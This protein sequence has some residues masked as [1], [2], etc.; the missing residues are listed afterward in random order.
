L[1]LV[2]AATRN[3]R[4]KVAGRDE[5]AILDRDDNRL[6]GIDRGADLASV[7]IAQPRARRPAGHQASIEKAGS[8]A[9]ILPWPDRGGQIGGDAAG[10]TATGEIADMRSATGAVARR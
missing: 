1:H 5:T 4:M 6:P 10:F 8:F 7:G 3:E 2:T 9:L